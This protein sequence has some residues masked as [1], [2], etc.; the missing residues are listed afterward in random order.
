MGITGIGYEGLTIDSFV[1]RLRLRGVQVLVDVRL[2]AISRKPGFAKKALSAALQ[3]A[4]IVYLHRPVLGNRRD[5]R[6]G[7]GEIESPAAARARHRYQE[8]IEG[9]EA[10]ECLREVAEM[11]NNCE[12]VL[13]CF[14]EDERHCH[15]EQTLE[16]VRQFMAEELVSS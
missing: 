3:E 1:S 6:D 8:S 14:E 16:A 2:N 12:V 11:A 10:S 4:G 7:Y 5:N 9:A 15:R 13:M